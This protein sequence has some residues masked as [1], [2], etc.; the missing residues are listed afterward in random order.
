MNQNTD[1]ADAFLGLDCGGTRS[2]AIYQSESEHR[3]MEAGAGNVRLLNDTQLL[4]LFR[5][6]RTVHKNLASPCAVGIGM[7]GARMEV[8]RERVRRIAAK[9]WPNTPCVAVGD[10]DT[11]LAAAEIDERVGQN[12]LSAVVIALSGT[13]SCFFGKNARGRYMKVGGWGHIVGD[14]GSGYEIGL[15]ALKAAL[16]YFDRGGRIPPLG[17]HLLRALLLNELNDIPPWALSASKTEIASLAREV[18]AAA[19]NGDRIARDIL[20]GAAHSIAT[21]A[22]TCAARLAQRGRRVKFVFAGG[23]LLNQPGF[24]RRVAKQIRDGWAGAEVVPLKHEAALGAIALAREL[25]SK[26]RGPKPKAAS[27]S[28]LNSQ[29]STSPQHWSSDIQLTDSPTEQRNPHS[30]HLDRLPLKRAMQ[31]MLAEDEKIPA[32]ILDEGEQIERAVESIVRSF[33]RG[34]H[35]FYV[36]AGTS[37][38]L[39]VLDA[40]ECPPTFRTDPEMVQGIIAGGQ[41]AL[42]RAIE[43]AEDDPSAGAR[44]VISRGVNARDT[45]VGIATSGRTPFVWGALDEAKQH[46]ASTVLMTFNPNLKI[47]R[48][49]R[50]DI[51]IAPNVGPEILTGSTR[52]KSGTATKMILNIFTT[53]AMVRIGKVLSNLMVDVKATNTKLR[54]RAVRIVRTLTGTNEDVAR[55]ALDRTNWVIKDAVQRVKRGS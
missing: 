18:F 2:A 24:Q 40:S 45:V 16:F 55:V 32:A 23:V 27:L 47:P 49:H 54:D 29:L 25:V 5:S 48:E 42:W 36:G 38:R 51:L 22:M 21:D 50:P 3:R 41:T 31:L 19:G 52:L 9:V 37:G 15:R 26:A 34:G 8:D 14:K 4:A 35:L 1:A 30:M 46:G 53:L 44:A 12:Q 28:T 10:L 17:Q 43:G 11:A 13:G 6:L 33:K 20:E 39:G 7:A